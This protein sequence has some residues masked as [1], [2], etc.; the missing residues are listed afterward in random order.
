MSSSDK[1]LLYY[2]T[3]NMYTVLVVIYIYKASFG[4]NYRFFSL[5]DVIQIYTFVELE[6]EGAETENI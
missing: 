3:C 5:N 4:E 1:Y 6:V 2:R